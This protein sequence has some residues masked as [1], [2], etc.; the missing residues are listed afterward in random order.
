MRAPSSEPAALV[1]FGITGNLAQRMLLPALYHLEHEDQLHDNFRI[2]GVL[3]REPDVDKLLAAAHARLEESGVTVDESVMK[4]LRSRITVLFMDSTNPEHFT[5]LKSALDALND[6]TGQTLPHLFYLAIPP[7]IFRNVISNL[8]SVGLN[9]STGAGHSSRIL[10]EKPFGDDL[11][12]ARELIEFMSQHFGEDQIYRIDHY[13]AKE[14]AQNILTFRFHNPLVQGFWSN[15]FID[16]IHITAAEKIGVEG[17]SNFYE[18]MGA[19][20]DFVQSHLM[21]LMALVMMEYPEGLTAAQI[22]AE[23]L[24][25]LKSIVP[26]TPES[27]ANVAVRGQYE[28]YA[29]EVGNPDSHVE[30][31]AALKLEVAN[32]RWSGV[33]VLVR[34]G[35]ALG[36]KATEIS[37]VF[38]DR[39]DHN[40]QENILVIRIQPNEG[41]SLGLVAK[42]PGFDTQLQ[43][44]NMEFCYA[45]TFDGHQPD[46]YQRVLVDAMRG[47]QTLFATNAE[48]LTSWELLEPVLEAWQSGSDAPNSY[49]QGSWG[50][51]AAED[52]A[53]R[54]G[55]SWRVIGDHV[56]AVH[57]AKAD[58][59]K[60]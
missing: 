58:Q 22:H 53:E 47:D 29:E 12:S 40:L 48:V 16:H 52:L 15:K 41:I 36:A 34:T 23:K 4:R 13:L 20:R 49:K 44:V 3:R 57:P 7:S 37:V 32:D 38:K 33:P 45:G 10:V 56:C 6:E 43:P 24:K 26:I 18:N 46:A 2:I 60:K 8:A 59:P 21:Q 28:G 25:L 14:T 35:K 27:V 51:Q 54:F 1:I 5:R 19:L 55:C 50:P 31:Y 30:T 17:R 11:S 39:T 9:K 42:K